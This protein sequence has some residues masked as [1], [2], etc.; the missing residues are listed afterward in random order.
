MDLDPK[1]N[2]SD[3]EEIEKYILHKISSLDSEFVSLNKNYD[4]HKIYID[5]LNF[6]TIDLSALYFDIR[7]DSLYCD[8]INSIKRINCTKI[9]SIIAQFLLKW[10]SPILVFT[11]EEIYQTS[12]KR[13]F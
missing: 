8:D 9:L 10:L 1:I 12:K 3:L 13:K 5:I 11:C 7:K 2:L 6:C 4:F